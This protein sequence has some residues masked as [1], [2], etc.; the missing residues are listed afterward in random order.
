MSGHGNLMKCKDEDTSTSS[1]PV[2]EEFDAK[3][4]PESE[5]EGS[6]VE[7]PAQAS[8]PSVLESEQPHEPET[9]DPNR[10]TQ[11]N[12]FQ[13]PWIDVMSEP[14]QQSCRQLRTQ[15]EGIASNADTSH[16][17]QSQEPLSRRILRR[18][19]ECFHARSGSCC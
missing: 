3:E 16:I 19:R 13:V 7:V 2:K 15:V 17:V 9:P 11:E 18:W 6:R 8:Q 4:A 5:S 12:L 14:V 10:D 1:M